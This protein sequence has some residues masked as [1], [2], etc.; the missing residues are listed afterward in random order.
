[1]SVFRENC[2]ATDVARA[3][4]VDRSTVSRILNRSFDRH[5]YAPE[6]IDAVERA[7]Q[8]LNYRPSTTARALRTG[9]TMLVGLVVG[10]ISNSFF[11]QLTGAIEIGLRA[12]GY[13]L[14]IGSTSEDITMQ[15]QHLKEMLHRG[16]DGIIIS[17]AGISGLKQAASSS[18]PVVLVDRPLVRS[19]LPYVGIDN[20]D[21]GRQLGEHLR[22]L[23]YQ[24][25]GAVLPD[26]QDDP[27]LRWRLQ[28]L[29]VGL[30]H[31]GRIMWRHPVPLRSTE[32]D[33]RELAQCLLQS[34][35]R[36]QAVVGLTNDCT[37]TAMEAIRDVGWRVPERIGLAGI[38]DFR[39]AALL[40]PPLT[41]MSQPIESIAA[42]AVDYLLNAMSGQA[43]TEDRL[44]PPRLI[45]RRSLRPLTDDR[46]TS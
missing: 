12:H 21:A 8:R 20:H 37:V 18:T 23:G 28:G 24:A 35:P 6:T 40:D 34:S 45:E 26:T 30:G 44:L 16:V 17:P 14:L 19:N 9:R 15:R 4:G 11:G 42:T 31:R 1:M 10:D 13:R 3:A 41:V 46:E 33:R 5:R 22:G 43:K 2:T 29:K 32:N 25:I 38:D 27:T 39:A 36:L 7:A